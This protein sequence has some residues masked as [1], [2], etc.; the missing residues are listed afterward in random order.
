MSVAYVER[1]MLPFHI[2]LMWEL[3]SHI[4]QILDEYL[5]PGLTR[6]RGVC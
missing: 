6:I 5:T 2:Y 1:F 4:V 3:E